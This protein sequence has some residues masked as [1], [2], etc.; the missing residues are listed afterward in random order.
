[1]TVVCILSKWMYV[2]GN[3]S[4]VTPNDK[5][6]PQKTTAS[7]GETPIL[8]SEFYHY[9]TILTFEFPKLGLIS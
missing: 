3:S 1:M 2:Y 4:A 9:K 6:G 5:L 7:R 8:G